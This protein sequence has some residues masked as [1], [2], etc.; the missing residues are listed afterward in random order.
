MAW[1]Y[2]TIFPPHK[3]TQ[4]KA[5]SLPNPS[6]AYNDNTAEDNADNDAADNNADNNADF[7][8]DND[9]AM[10]TTDNN[11]DVKQRR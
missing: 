8:A 11:A 1:G 5:D 9:N 2:H 6:N 7:D 4:D 10:Q 3:Y